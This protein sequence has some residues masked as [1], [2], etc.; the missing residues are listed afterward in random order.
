MSQKSK[1]KKDEKEP[2]E[3][4]LDEQSAQQSGD[5]ELSLE[6]QL[7]QAANKADENWDKYLRA[8]AEMENIRKRSAREAEN[9]R[10][11]SIESF[12][13]EI[14]TVVDTF[15]M[16][17]ESDDLNIDDLVSGNKSTM[18]LIKNILEQFGVIMIDPHGEP[19]NPEFHEAMSMQ[20]SDKL[21]PGTVLTVY[22]KGYTL[23]DRLL[24]PARVVVATEPEEKL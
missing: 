5:E 3:T 9:A 13:K 1:D 14:I 15:E 17:M 21:E 20:Q 12:A 10:K 8:V 19:F 18:Q 11:Y 16:S 7:E 6:E 24:R 23:N 2:F 22:Q 4:E